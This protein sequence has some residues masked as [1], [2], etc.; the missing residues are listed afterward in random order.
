MRPAGRKLT[1]LTI[2]K[3]SEEAPFGDSRSLLSYKDVTGGGAGDVKRWEENETHEKEQIFTVFWTVCLACVIIR[4]IM[5][6]NRESKENNKTSGGVG[7]ETKSFDKEKIREVLKV[8]SDE[9]EA[10]ANEIAPGFD[11]E[12]ETRRLEAADTRAE[13][14]ELEREEI[15]AKIKELLEA[16]YAKLES[17]AD[18]IAPDFDYKIESEKLKA[19]EENELREAEFEWADEPAG[20]ATLE[21]AATVSRQ[22]DAKSKKAESR[23]AAR[24]ARRKKSVGTKAPGTVAETIPANASGT[25]SETAAMKDSGIASGKATDEPAPLPAPVVSPSRYPKPGRV[26]A[27]AAGRVL[28]GDKHKKT[29][30]AAVLG[31]AVFAGYQAWDYLV[32]KTVSL[33]YRTY[34]E[35]FDVQYKTKARNAGELM[36]EITEPGAVVG[37]DIK[38]AATDVLV[39]S[40]D[41]PVKNG[42]EIEVMKATK[43]DASIAGEEL[44][45]WLIPGTVKETLEHNGIAYDEDD[46]ISPGRNISVNADTEIILKDIRYEEAEKKETV[47]AKDKVVLDPGL[48]SGVQESSEGN[49]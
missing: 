24:A 3:G 47:K 30:T 36:D 39:Q 23:T 20:T 35:T 22:P 2:I 21:A 49:D 32:P 9:I 17:E 41:I 16:E 29:L 37:E 5:A 48:T 42:T 38:I 33:S 25:V 27:T 34:D 28:L 31:C 44:D 19:E 15:K 43:T 7:R 40:E 13:T 26:P 11:Y 46:E 8:K 4:A 18:R 1:I 12:E 45:I 14:I 10:A 6:E